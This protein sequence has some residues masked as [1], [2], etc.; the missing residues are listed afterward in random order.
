MIFFPN[1]KDEHS[2]L[3]FNLNSIFDFKESNLMDDQS[4]FLMN[5]LPNEE[6]EQK[7]NLL[8]VSPSSNGSENFFMDF[9]EKKSILIENPS[10]SDISSPKKE[11]TSKNNDNDYFKTIFTSRVDKNSLQIPSYEN[12]EE[13]FD[14]S[15]SCIDEDLNEFKNLF[16]IKPIFNVVYPKRESLF[17]KSEGNIFSIEKEKKFLKRKRESR[18]DDLDNIRIK[19]KRRFLNFALINK[20]NEKLKA[21]GITH[22]FYIFP[23]NLVRDIQKKRNNKFFK[24]T[25]LELFENKELYEFKDKDFSIVYENNLKIIKQVKK[26]EVFKNIL[27]KTICEL[28]EEYINSE[29]FKINEINRLKYIKKEKDE[30]ISIYKYLAYNLIKFF[31]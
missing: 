1:D 30:Y 25:L 29:E 2:I 28:Y 10:N 13:N 27:N 31:Q 21:N 4:S 18:K 8:N 11:K 5:F 26:N 17:T 12:I 24:I 19:I 6:Q 16:D 7:N 9:E 20:L 15:F 3:S 23:D 14:D 22:N